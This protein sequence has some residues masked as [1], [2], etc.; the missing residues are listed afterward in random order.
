MGASRHPCSNT[1]QGPK[2]NSEPEVR[3]AEENLLAVKDNVR[4]S[5]SL[6]SQGEPFM[7]TFEL[8]VF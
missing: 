5:I 2:E 4:A 3:T 8:I 6:H 1:Y 7:S